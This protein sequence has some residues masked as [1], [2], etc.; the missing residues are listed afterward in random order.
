MILGG[1]QRAFML[2]ILFTGWGLMM[3]A[4]GGGSAMA[5]E[6]I[7]DDRIIQREIDA[8]R[9][10]GGV[11]QL[12]ARTYI[13]T[14]AIVL[15]D[16]ITLK[17]AGRDRTII[18]LADGANPDPVDGRIPFANRCIIRNENY[19]ELAAPQGN[20]DITIRDLT[21]DGNAEN[22][23][24]VGEGILLS[25]C[26]NYRIENV[27]VRNCRGFAG[28][29]TNPC[30]LAARRKIKYRNYILNCIVEDQQPATDR[31]APYGHGFYITAWD[32][33]NVLLKGCIARNNA[34]AG[35]H[36]EDFISYF[37][38]EENEV[39]GNNGPGIWFCEVRNSVIK[40]NKV[41]HNGSDG[42]H[43]SQGR[44]N[45]DN[46]VCGNEVHH[47]GNHGISV[48]RQYDPGESFCLIL[49]N[50][51]WDNRG[52]GIF[53]AD[54]AGGN[55]IGF[56]LC[57]DE[58]NADDSRQQYGILVESKGNRIVN[59]YVA[60]NAKGGIKAVEGNTVIERPF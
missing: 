55:T 10:K 39:Y 48:S 51:V 17:G 33:D 34:G 29:Y 20:H 52:A 5:E 36:G 9:D 18:R 35:I 60:G 7:P 32:N 40:G 25:N 47:N 57:Y 43:L 28:I 3:F 12:E 49:D 44:G 15:Y 42:I 37:F 45:R 8:L 2:L 13:V 56:N 1:K 31:D 30:H 50:R 16:N 26:Y 59:N 14:R 53:I 27:R 24:Y 6:K 19:D 23:L 46:L 38:V 22:N 41:H 58:G 11:V 21:I 4:N 54:S